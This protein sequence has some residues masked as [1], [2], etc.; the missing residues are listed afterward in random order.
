MAAVEN[1]AQLTQILG[2]ALA[3]SQCTL[4]EKCTNTIRV[5]NG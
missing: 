5:R 1:S 3:M 2:I 4:G